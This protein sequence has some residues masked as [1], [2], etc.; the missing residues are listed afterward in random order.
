MSK[1]IRAFL[2]ACM[3]L[4]IALPI[5]AQIPNLQDLSTVNVDELSDQQIQQIAVRFEA[6]GIQDFEIDQIAVSRGMSPAMAVKLK[7]RIINIKKPGKEPASPTQSRD[8]RSVNGSK[9]REYK[10][11]QQDFDLDKDENKDVEFTSSGKKTQEKRS[12]IFGADLFNKKN[13]TFEPNLRLATPVDYE[14]GPDDELLIDIYGY[15]EASYQLVVSPEGTINIPMAGVVLVGGTT[16]EQANLRIRNK[17]SAIYSGIETGA[18]S[19]RVSLGNIRSIKVIL[20]G[21]ITKPG[22]YTLPSVATVFNALY[23]SGG[24]D[25]NGSFRQ[26]QVVRANKVIATLDVYDFLLEGSM[27]NNIRLQDQ[28]VIRVPV[29]KTKVEI[30]GMVKRPGIYEMKPGESVAD[31]IRFAG[32]FKEGS[33]KSRIKLIR[34]N[35]KEKEVRDITFENLEKEIPVNGDQFFVEEVL[36]RYANRVEV[37]GAFFRTGYFELKPGM[38]LSE[39]IQKAEGLQEDAFMHRGYITRLKPD[40]SREIVSFSPQA[41]ISGNE[42]IILQREDVV[43][44]P[45][46]F[47]LR[48]EYNLTINGE[49]QNPGVYPYADGTS[50]KDLIL[51]AGGFRESAIAKRIEIS[52]RI[53]NGNPL[54]DTSTISQVIVMDINKDL[55]ENDKNFVLMPYDIISVRPSPGYEIQKMV[56][57]E[58]EVLFPGTYAISHKNERISDIIKR[59][60]GLTS[61]AYTE[62]AAL[63]RVYVKTSQLEQ[64]KEEYRLQQLKEIQLASAD[65]SADIDLSRL[66]IRND[67]V[68]INLPKILANPGKKEDLLLEDGDI[69]HV[70]KQLQTV[71]V[72]G[73]VLSPSSMV[74]QSG[75]LKSYINR[76][77]GFSP[78]ALKKHAYIVYANGSAAATKKFLFFNV[79]PT[80]KPG[81]EIFVPRK[82]EKKNKLSTT[83]II[84][85]STGLA[86]FATLIY[87]I[88]K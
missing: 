42:D 28:D 11:P 70:P 51:I 64:E 75:G 2:A 50:L 39:L 53:R 59:A 48:E 77:G 66:A 85:I 86:T 40:L 71:K 54:S 22:T 73:E 46:I 52:R 68:G 36:N 37:K 6:A 72:S 8:K 87:T 62:G 83:E 49:V 65:S 34:S 67:F 13:L 63:K 19:V 1:L 29:Y 38:K 80:V 30:S 25:E 14:I 4:C 88:F 74:Y 32:D 79:Y 16:I 12:K 5:H 27:H 33:Y 26:I 76:S 24:P 44:V 41:I 3:I 17:L 82:E 60:G 20:T 58:G 81:S 43:T 9:S 56:R 84:S 61:S 78:K 23:A 69:I 7:A 21:E 47:D 35:D 45:S 15:S 18:T 31:L 55:S 10:D 57:I